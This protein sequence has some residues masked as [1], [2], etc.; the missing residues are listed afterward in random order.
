LAAGIH[1]HQ[2][3]KVTQEDLDALADLHHGRWDFGDELKRVRA[4]G[5]IGLDFHYDFASPEQQEKLLR[6]Q[7]EMAIETGRPA[8]IHARQSEERVC[9]ILGEYRALEGKVV[10]HCFSGGPE[11]A[12]RVLDLGDLLSFTGVVTFK[13]AG[14]IRESARL[15][16]ADRILVETDAPFLTPEPIRKIRP[17]EPAY[18]VH[19]A[20]FL[21]EIRNEALDALAEATTRNAERFFGMSGE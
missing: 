1:P 20:R 19:T 6:R 17:C 21:A 14:A 12:R 11:I 16:P 9:E 4:V 18:V 15:A 8:V 13:N 3:A 10:F 5:E 7:L 2:A